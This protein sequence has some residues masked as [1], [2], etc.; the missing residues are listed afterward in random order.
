MNK[1][2]MEAGKVRGAWASAQTDTI[3]GNMI[4]V[5]RHDL[6]TT[7]MMPP[8]WEGVE[9]NPIWQAALPVLRVKFPGKSDFQLVTEVLQRVLWDQDKGNNKTD[10]LYALLYMAMKDGDVTVD[11]AKEGA[12]FVRNAWKGEAQP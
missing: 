4:V 3:A 11:E 9:S 6:T 1:V 12:T 5:K 2:T 10:L 7:V 8:E